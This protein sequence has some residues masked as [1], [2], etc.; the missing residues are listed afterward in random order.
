MGRKR[1]FRSNS[2]KVLAGV[3]GGLGEYFNLSSLLIRIIFIFSGLGLFCYLL[4]ALF[5]PT[6]DY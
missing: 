1:L 4:M 2:D 3:C 5:I 6:E